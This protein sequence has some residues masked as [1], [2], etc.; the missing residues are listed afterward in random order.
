MFLLLLCL[1]Y[2]VINPYWVHCYGTVQKFDT[3]CGCKCQIPFRSCQTTEFAVNCVQTRH[4]CPKRLI[5]THLIIQNRY[6]NVSMAHTSSQTSNFFP[7]TIYHSISRMFPI[8]S[9]SNL[10]RAS[11]TFGDTLVEWPQ[12]TSVSHFFTVAIDGADFPCKCF[13]HILT[14][15]KSKGP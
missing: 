12:R 10:I 9:G 6:H 14:T 13:R 15:G 1:E 8:I 5:H 11:S 2:G 7:T 3:E 4:L